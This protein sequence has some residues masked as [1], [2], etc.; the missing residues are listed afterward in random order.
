MII[1]RI[2]WFKDNTSDLFISKLHCVCHVHDQRTYMFFALNKNIFFRV[3]KASFSIYILSQVTGQGHRVRVTMNQHSILTTLIWKTYR[4]LT[5]TFKAPHRQQ[6]HHCPMLLYFL[7]TCFPPPKC[8]KLSFPACA[9]DIFVL[10]VPLDDVSYRDRLVNKNLQCL[11]MVLATVI[12]YYCFF[13][14]ISRLA[15]MWTN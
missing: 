7:F 12:N 8:A 10:I 14:I 9:L 1:Y 4:T 15:F 11:L 13:C 2:F 6:Q 5:Q 3:L